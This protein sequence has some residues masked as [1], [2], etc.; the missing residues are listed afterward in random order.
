MD[1]IE[2]K[3]VAQLGRKFGQQPDLDDRLSYIGVDSVGMA[4]LT[5]EIEKE[6]GIKVAEDIFSVDTVRELAAYIRQRQSTAASS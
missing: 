5:V 4:E 6:F 2:S 3:L 1:S